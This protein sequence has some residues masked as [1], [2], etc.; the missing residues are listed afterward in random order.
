MNNLSYFL[1]APAE[2][3]Q[4]GGGWSMLLML[5]AFFLIMWLFMIRPQQKRAKKE[6]EA[7]NA[8]QKGDKVITIGGL[9]GKIAEV[10]E[11]TFLIEVSDGV[12]IK[13]EKSAIAI[14]PNAPTKDESKK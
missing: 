9:H 2:G 6:Q 7:R 5:G 3:A 14:N 10:Q 4:G 1:M 11:T 8:M 12:K 13:V